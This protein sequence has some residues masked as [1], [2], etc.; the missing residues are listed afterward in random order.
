M[1]GEQKGEW[2]VEGTEGWTGGREGKTEERRKGGKSGDGRKKPN[3][4]P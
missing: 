3:L 1:C 2:T 4:Q